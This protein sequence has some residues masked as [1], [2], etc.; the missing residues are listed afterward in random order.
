[1]PYDSRPPR[2]AAGGEHTVVLDCNG[3]IEAVLAGAEHS[4]QQG[5]DGTVGREHVILTLIGGKG[6]KTRT[7]C[8][9]VKLSTET[10]ASRD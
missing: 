2:R 3:A 5:L 7:A 9:E 8:R 4:K 10:C 1:M 6:G